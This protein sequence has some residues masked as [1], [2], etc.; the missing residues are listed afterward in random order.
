[1]S[2]KDIMLLDQTAVRKLLL[3]SV[4][5]KPL[6]VPP[7]IYNE[8][9]GYAC[10][11]CNT[12]NSG[13][14]SLIRQSLY[15]ELIKFITFP[16]ANEKIGCEI[17]L[18]HDE[19]DLHEK[20]C[21][22][23]I[24]SCP[25]SCK[26]LEINNVCPWIGTSDCLQEHLKTHKDLF[27]DPPHIEL[28]MNLKNRIFFTYVGIFV[29]AI[30]IKQEA[31]KK[32]KVLITMNGTELE[33]QCFRYQV[34]LLNADK[35]ISL[36]L[37]EN[38]L[39]SLMDFC[40]NLKKAETQLELNYENLLEL[41]Q[42]PEHL[43][44]KFNIAKKSKKEIM[45]IIGN[46]DSLL[47]KGKEKLE[48]EKIPV[49]DNDLLL[50][51]ECPVCSEYMLP[52]IFMCATGHSI[53][54]CC[55]PK[56]SSCPSCR[57]HI[58]NGRCFILENLTLKVNFP[59]KNR[60]IGCQFVGTADIMKTHQSQCILSDFS[61]VLDC[62]WKGA[63]NDFQAHLLS[64]HEHNLLEHNAF[65]AT[66]YSEPSV[67]FLCVHSEVFCV[68][69]KKTT[70]EQREEGNHFQEVSIKRIHRENEKPSFKYTIEF[71]KGCS[72]FKSLCLSNIPCFSTLYEDF[73]PED[74]DGILIPYNLLKPYT[75]E[76]YHYFKILVEKM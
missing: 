10:G 58:T 71:S 39:Y 62:E 17:M 9:L 48:K 12:K 26:L 63:L 52:P 21:K 36:L 53:C 43:I 35:N 28:S 25:I 61:C 47:L 45:E 49:P 65:H 37:K 66:E 69:L 19:V 18:K 22:Y 32:Y 34:E 23:R 59:C 44:M 24:I 8:T 74:G 73:D 46:N 30:A 2:S 11:R 27:L 16:C 76:D 57:K 41:L 13:I 42:K 64:K 68:T 72:N 33:S 1:M 70:I 54:S 15:E 20:T 4:C 55:K 51:L 38:R 5:N 60:D 14:S 56:V 7:I 75:N 67:L 29:M 31:D 6:N 40:E 3:C 50:E